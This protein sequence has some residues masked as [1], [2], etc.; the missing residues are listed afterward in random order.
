MAS[1]ME[2]GMDGTGHGTE[3]GDGARSR[4][5]SPSG[6]VPRLPRGDE[7][8]CE[9]SPV[10]S[11][12]PREALPSP[13]ELGSSESPRQLDTT[14][15]SPC[16]GSTVRTLRR[17]GSRPRECH[18]SG[19]LSS[20][21]AATSEP[22]TTSSLPPR[23]T[24][25]TGPPSSTSARSAEPPSP[26]RPTRRPS[27]R[28]LPR[29]RRHPPAAGAPDHQRTRR[30]TARRR[31]SRREPGPSSVTRVPDLLEVPL[32]DPLSGPLGGRV[33]V[34]DRCRPE[35]RLRHPRLPRSGR[36]GAQADDLPGLRRPRRQPAPL[37][38]ARPPGL[39]ADGLGGAERRAPCPHPSRDR[40]PGLVPDHPERRRAARARRAAADGRAARPHQR[41]HLPRLWRPHPP[42]GDAARARRGQ[43]RLAGRARGSHGPARRGRRARGDRA[44]RRTWLRRVR[45]TAQAGRRLL[46]GERAQAAGGAVLRG[47]RR[48]RRPAR[49]RLLAERDVRPPLRPLRRQ[50]R[51]PGRHREPWRHPGRRPRHRE[52]R[53][54]VQRVAGPMG[55]QRS[56]PTRLRRA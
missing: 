48:G 45:R 24:R 54:R 34:A 25:C 21:C 9:V 29:S 10:R 16:T 30:R 20:A 7:S 40:R 4:A 23:G 42:H 47:S 26:R 39:V 43:P 22:C 18:G 55:D 17:R 35:H 37:L 12:C 38:G 51:P 13:G 36:A 56:H 27:T 28:Q 19:V 46:R 14:A 33:V 8:C 32:D 1:G 11:S 15:G 31:P 49:R 53:G 44:V 5:A 41:R 6:A 2:P 3:H 52:D 50:G